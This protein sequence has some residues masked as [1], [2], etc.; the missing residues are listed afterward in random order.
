[1]RPLSPRKIEVLS[2]IFANLS[3]GYFG[4][5]LFSPGLFGLPSFLSLIKILTLNLPLGILSMYIAM[6]LKEKSY[7]G[8]KS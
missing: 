6:Y 8:N 2:E 7:A 5:I 1:M 3:A 4:V